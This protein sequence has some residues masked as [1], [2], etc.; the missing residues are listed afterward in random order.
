MVKSS[1]SDVPT[2]GSKT[3]EGPQR[4]VATSI[5]SSQGD[6]NEQIMDCDEEVEIDETAM[7]YD[8]AMKEVILNELDSGELSCQE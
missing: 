1:T 2:G 5:S 6:E 4:S 8:F 7:N 3:T